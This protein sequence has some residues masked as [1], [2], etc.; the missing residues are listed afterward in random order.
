MKII[1]D[2]GSSVPWVKQEDCT[3]CG[4]C[5]EQC[6]VNAID[7]EH[8]KARINMDDCI[9]CGK[10]HD[11]CPQDAVRHDSELIPIEIEANIQKTKQL[12]NHFGSTQ[13]KID[14]LERMIKHFNKEKKV[15]EKSLEQTKILRDHEY[16][17]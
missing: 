13:E 10:C 15:A 2:R 3:G 12:M 4:I 1:I 8:D 5:V 7:L 6:P 9:R 14:F 16:T 11:V 17:R